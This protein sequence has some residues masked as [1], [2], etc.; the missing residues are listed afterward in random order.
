MAKLGEV[1]HVDYHDSDWGFPRKQTRLTANP[2]LAMFRYL[3]GLFAVTCCFLSANPVQAQ[4]FTV[5]VTHGQAEIGKSRD[6]YHAATVNS[7]YSIPAWGKTEDSSSMTI[8]FNPENRFRL[9]PNSEAQVTTGGEGDSNS[10]WHRVVSLKIGEASFDHN[11]GTAPTIHLDCETPTAVCGA[12]GT[13]YDVDATRGIYSVSQ[14][15][16]S[17]SSDQEDNLTLPSIGAGGSVIYDPGQENTY[18]K[19]DFTGTVILDGERFHA[20]DAN[21]T[22]A[23]Q[24]GSSSQTAVRIAS[25][26]LGGVGPGDYLMDGGKLQP[27]T[28][29]AVAIHPQY[30]AAAKTE[31]ALSVER[32]VDRAANRPFGRDAELSR[33]TAEATR[34]RI[35]LFTRETVRETVKQTVQSIIEQ[36]T[37][38]VIGH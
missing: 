15:S 3:P 12:V 4:I 5:S 38:N 6:S 17:V 7:S 28:G 25:G 32:A 14:G 18:S 13:V 9:L 8:A 27:V 19:G 26:T 31:G 37:R 16:I 2:P 30:L 35:A 36:Q 33:A 29:K 23:K 21:F 10:A 11:A 1:H 34:L 24:K 20:S 22:V